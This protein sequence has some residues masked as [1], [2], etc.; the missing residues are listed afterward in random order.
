[1]PDRP[2]V[3]HRQQVLKGTFPP[4]LGDWRGDGGIPICTLLPPCPGVP[5]GRLHQGDLLVS[6]VYE[7]PPPRRRRT[8]LRRVDSFIAG[9]ACQREC[10]CNAG[11]PAVDSKAIQRFGSLDAEAK[12]TPHSAGSDLCKENCFP[13]LTV[14]NPAVVRK[15]T[16][17][18]RE[19]TSQG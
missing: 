11:D 8:T 19:M 15:P 6:G 2:G 16:N 10:R 17:P 12:G 9:I 13:W 5:A 3:A 14:R 4:G 18:P 7:T 1:M